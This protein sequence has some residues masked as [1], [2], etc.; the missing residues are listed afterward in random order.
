MPISRDTSVWINIDKSTLK[1][2]S[3]LRLNPTSRCGPKFEDLVELFTI[4]MAKPQDTSR[5][6][7]NGTEKYWMK[8]EGWFSQ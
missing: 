1:V 8:L 3:I 4:I 7:E 5:F 6:A 2:R